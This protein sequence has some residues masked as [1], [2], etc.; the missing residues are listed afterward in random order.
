MTAVEE[1][2]A[3]L[4]AR[5]LGLT[6]GAVYIARSRVLSR[7]RDEVKKWEDDDALS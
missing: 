5:E 2:E 6:V 3:E 1:R 7:L 4:V